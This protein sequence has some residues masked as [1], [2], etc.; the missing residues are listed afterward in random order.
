MASA[1]KATPSPNDV[2]DSMF[3]VQSP[4]KLEDKMTKDGE[5]IAL[6]CM[7]FYNWRKQKGVIKAWKGEGKQLFDF[8]NKA[9]NEMGHHLFSFRSGDDISADDDR[10][11]FLKA[12]EPNQFEKN[13]YRYVYTLTT[14]VKNFSTKKN[15]TAVAF[16]KILNWRNDLQL[17]NGDILPHP[18]TWVEDE[19]PMLLESMLYAVEDI[20]IVQ[21][22]KMQKNANASKK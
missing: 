2:Y 9:I 21:P 6:W 12:F 8:F 19:P 3:Y 22:F 14:K 17:E 5:K 15:M 10:T 7:E 11:L 20:D 13:T 16:P 1:E 18:E 4:G